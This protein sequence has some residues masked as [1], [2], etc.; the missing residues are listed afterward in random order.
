MFL[1]LLLSPSRGMVVI[2][3]FLPPADQKWLGEN[4]PI[5]C[6]NI[7]LDCTHSHTN[8]PEII[9]TW[10]LPLHCSRW[11]FFI[12][13]LRVLYIRP[14]I[15]LYQHVMQKADILFCLVWCGFITCILLS[16]TRQAKL[17]WIFWNLYLVLHTLASS[18]CLPSPFLKQKKIDEFTTTK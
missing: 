14:L 8:W 7:H 2:N 5:M 18:L 1:I 11:K 4:F 16:V 17:T 13:C 12:I 3:N 6:R 9:A 15:P 10:C